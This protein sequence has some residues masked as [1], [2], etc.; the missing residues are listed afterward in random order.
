L[1]TSKTVLGTV[2]KPQTSSAGLCADCVNARK[3]ASSRGSEFLLC[4]LSRTD[5]QYPKYPRLPVL[6]CAGYKKSEKP[7]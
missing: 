1:R 5:A 3:I 4:E 7:V 2:N 6:K